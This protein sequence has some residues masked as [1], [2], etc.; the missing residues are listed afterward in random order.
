MPIPIPTEFKP[1]FFEE[2]PGLITDKSTIEVRIW[3]YDNNTAAEILHLNLRWGVEFHWIVKGP[4]VP[5][6]G[7]HFDLEV[8][9]ESLG[10][11]PEYV[12]ATKVVPVTAGV[13]TAP[14]T[15]EYDVRIPILVTPPREGVYAISTHLHFT[16][17]FGGKTAAFVESKEVQFF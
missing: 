16:G 12:L 9:S 2:V 15:V 5:F 1:G 11:G 17:T 14:D 3:D 13:F 4:V 7:G 8:N 6:L 10:T